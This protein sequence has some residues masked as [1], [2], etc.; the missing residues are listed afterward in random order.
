M[1]QNNDE[2]RGNGYG[3]GPIN[4]GCT[5]TVGQPYQV[6]I[7][8]QVTNII[9]DSSS[10]PAPS[11]YQMCA[12]YSNAPNSWIP[13]PG[14]N[15]VLYQNGCCRGYI[16]N[17][18]VGGGDTNTDTDTTEFNCSDL[19]SSVTPYQNNIQGEVVI[20]NTVGFGPGPLSNAAFNP[21]YI[22][23]VNGALDQPLIDAESCC[24]QE[25]IGFPVE[26]L[27]TPYSGYDLT[28]VNLTTEQQQFILGRC[29]T[30]NGCAED[31]GQA[32]VNTSGLYV[33]NNNSTTFFPADN[34]VYHQIGTTTS[35]GIIGEPCCTE[36]AVG[37]PV[38][39][40]PVLQK[41][42]KAPDPCPTPDLLT[43]DNVNTTVIG[44]LNEECCTQEVT[45]INSV[46]WDNTTQKC[47]FTINECFFDSVETRPY[48]PEIENLTTENIQQVFGVVGTNSQPLSES[49]CKADIV[50]YEVTWNP[51]LKICQSSVNS[52]VD[53]VLNYEPISTEDCDDLIVTCK[54]FFA[55]PLGTCVGDESIVVS[56]LPNNPTITVSQ[57]DVFDSDVDGFDT[58]TNLSA[59][60]SAPSGATFNLNLNISGGIV[61][62]CD[63]DVRVDDIRVDCYREEERIF[64]DIKKCV[65][66]DLARVIDN[67][68]SWV[69]NPGSVD[70]GSVNDNLIRERGEEGL[71][72]GYG[73]I[74]RTFA[75]SADADIPWRYT[76]YYVQSNILEPHSRSV[77]NSKE[78]E[79]TFNMCSECC[80]VYSECPAGYTSVTTS[81]GTKYCTKT[82]VYCSN[83]YTLSGGTCYSGVT[84]A[85]TLSETLTA[86]TGSYCI[87][88]AN[89]L[90]LEEYKKV[91]QSFWVRMIEQFIPATTIFISGEKWCNNDAFICPQFDICDYDFEYVDSEI[92]VIEYSTD[93]T[94][95][96][97]STNNPNGG[98]VDEPYNFDTPFSGDTFSA[99]QDSNN[100]RIAID[101][102]NITTVD[103]DPTGGGG[104]V[105]ARQLPPLS[106][107]FFDIAKQKY[108]NS[109]FKGGVK[110]VFQ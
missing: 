14:T 39:W 6:L 51:D 85:S 60:F 58:W 48:Q 52:S 5:L 75:P 10:D 84:T 93:F 91:F 78:M 33:Y 98:G 50:G 1:A 19:F 3:G 69:Y 38:N 88:T 67:K 17:G 96:S 86:S 103:N 100:G 74:N 70:F 35:F 59:R 89:L 8:G 37:F 57:I 76:D 32:V 65:G 92:T 49:C 31:L 26:W 90:Q 68:K 43:I 53:I 79:L 24:N 13:I 11:G 62:C 44:I 21:D 108:Y 99:P 66:F 54:L 110:E 82:T 2:V 27:N 41:C 63:Y 55:E 7:N 12:D 101:G 28:G 106:E 29:V 34:V 109:M 87:K 61:K 45:G 107:E 102:Y 23:I 94:P 20:V 40:D 15:P 77:I 46:Y 72:Q 42:F 104:I 9:I 80:S 18:T 4:F 97:G 105:V 36:Y 16:W 71:I 22:D 64:F 47:R 95:Q 25:T 83:G 73:F 30:S 81:G 56:L